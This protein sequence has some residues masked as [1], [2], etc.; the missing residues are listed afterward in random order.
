MCNHTIILLS[1]H[2]HNKQK[3]EH[4]IIL[5]YQCMYVHSIVLVNHCH[6]SGL[7]VGVVARK[8][9]YLIKLG[10]CMK[11]C[12]KKVQFDGLKDF[13]HSSATM[14]EWSLFQMFEATQCHACDI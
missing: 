6:S 7:L 12:F 9:T 5:I 13:L 3:N 10:K 1:T 2:V 14:S 11:V 8:A 4:C